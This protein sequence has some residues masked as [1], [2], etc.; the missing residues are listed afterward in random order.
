M[1]ILKQIYSELIKDLHLIIK[2]FFFLPKIKNSNSKKL[3]LIN[4][5]YH[6]DFSWLNYILGNILKKRGYNVKFLVCSGNQYCERMTYSIKKPNCQIC[7]ISNLIKIKSFGH[8]YIIPQEIK[9]QSEL[10][11]E[12]FSKNKFKI[13]KL[14]GIDYASNFNASFL[15]Y[16]KGKLKDIKSNVKVI[17]KLYITTLKTALSI[18]KIIEKLKPVKI[19]TINGKNIQTGILYK[20]AIQKNIDCYTWDIFN[21]G[22]KTMFSKN[23]IAHEQNISQSLWNKLKNSELYDKE[24]KII[25]SY[26]HLQSKSLN[27]PWKYYDENVI[28]KKDIVLKNLKLDLKNETISIFPNTD[29]DSTNIGLNDSYEDPFDFIEKIVKFAHDN[30]NYNVVIRCH[31]AEKKVNFHQRSSRPLDQFIKEEYAKFIKNNLFLVEAN[32]NISSYTLAN[33]SNHR[34][35]YTSTLGLE[36]SYMRL[37][38]LVAGKAFYKYRGFTQDII[39]HDN[40][41]EMI[42]NGYNKSLNNDEFSLLEK[43]IYISKFRK[44]F[45]LDYFNDAKITNITINELSKIDN[46]KIYN[47]IAD[48]IM[49]KRNYLDLDK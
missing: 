36:F 10:N 32:S 29:W 6:E 17:K 14:D 19:V 8:E 45:N 47:N 18:S 20:Q 46:N 41:I 26:M 15:H 49:D 33:I 4:N 3:I 7:K 16:F 42:K 35:V 22:F 5:Q 11:F 23:E 21:Q 31:P 48:Y 28:E 34:I 40:F 12:D 44:L 39:S 38:T 9:K 2:F 43:F 37:K 13:L 24:K 1:K 25:E 27:T 30:N